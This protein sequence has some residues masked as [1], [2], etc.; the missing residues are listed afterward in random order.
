MPDKERRYIS[1]YAFVTGTGAAQRSCVSGVLDD[2]AYALGLREPKSPAPGGGYAP[3]L[4][5]DIVLT[6]LEI[7][8]PNAWGRL[9]GAMGNE[10]GPMLEA[11]A[12]MPLDSLLGRWRSQLLSLRPAEAPVSVTRVL[13]GLTWTALLILGALGV[14]RWA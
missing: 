3:F 7:G 12:G 4:R 5:G 10:I 8:G 9:R 1:M 6:A 14:S 11:G 2:C 13:L